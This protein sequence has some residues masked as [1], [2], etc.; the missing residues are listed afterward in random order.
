MGITLYQFK[1]FSSD[2]LKKMFPTD[3]DENTDGAITC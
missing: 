3:E 2:L 1:L